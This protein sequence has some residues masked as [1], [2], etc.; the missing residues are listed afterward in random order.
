LEKLGIP[1]VIIQRPELMTAARNA[2]MGQGLPPEVPWVTFPYALYLSD[3]D[4]AGIIGPKVNEIFAG[5][6][7]WKS[8]STYTKG[9][10]ITREP[11][12]ITAKDYPT[13]WQNLQLAYLSKNWGDGNPVTPATKDMI[14]WI[15]TGVPEDAVTG[16]VPDRNA[17][18]GKGDGKVYPKCGILTYKSW[19]PAWRWPAGARSTCRSRLPPARPS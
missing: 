19:L 7:T 18:I 16:K 14:D 4:V 6:T 17:V 11:S 8:T 3:S 1:T 5:L 13:L 15:L 10:I 2:I 12:T 9:Q